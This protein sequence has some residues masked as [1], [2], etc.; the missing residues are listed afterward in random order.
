VARH[1]SAWWQ[2]LVTTHLRVPV[3]LPILL[4]FLTAVGP[5]STDMYLPGMPAIEASF[6]TPA[7][8]SQITLA[9]WL[10][11]LALGQIAQG[12]LSDRFGRRGPLLV[13]M[14]LY[15][16]A[17]IGCALAGDLTTLAAWRVVAAFGGSAGMVI[18][19]AVVR[20]YASGND[21]ARLMSQQMLVMGVAPILAP[22]LGGF[23]LTVTGWRG[24]FWFQAGF[25][26][27]GTLSV[28]A[29]LPDSLPLANRVRLDL[30]GLLQRY[31][32]ILT[33]RGFQAHTLVAGC[34]AI[35]VFAYLGGGPV[36]YV[37]MYGLS[38]VA[39][40]MVFGVNALAFIITAQL[41][42]LLVYRLGSPLL[43]HIG[44]VVF[45]VAAC[46]V[47]LVVWTGWGGIWAVAV[48]INVLLA[49]TGL[50]SPNSAVGALG[51]HAG[52]AGS[53]SALLGTIQYG[54]GAI[55]GTLVS[56]MADGTGRPMGTM[57]MVAAVLA[58]FA[59]RLRPVRR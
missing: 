28:L 54:M 11:G 1:P 19:R 35:G 58:I 33:E 17:T 43:L 56:L 45:A 12:T 8:A 36:I 7:G 38:P 48:P 57:M 53:A 18:P 24:I 3:W 41:N 52:Q 10:F 55:A 25:G 6:A 14:G 34:V 23:M 49:A 47:A 16:I 13:G 51:R 4:G 5:L 39:A 46:V 50:M 29:F 27:L 26:V 37:H 31:R 44:V 59:D 21:A 15:T 22:T 40:G 30:V 9:T 2:K 20:D 32:G 42:G